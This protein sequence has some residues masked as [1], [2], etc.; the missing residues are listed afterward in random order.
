MK[1]HSHSFRSTKLYLMI[2]IRLLFQSTIIC[3]SGSPRIGGL[4]KAHDRRI[5]ASRT[6][7][8]AS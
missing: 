1:R 5:C 2:A 7:A 3:L 6:G 4:I 8:S